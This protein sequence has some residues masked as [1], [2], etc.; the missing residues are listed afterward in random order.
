MTSTQQP[1]RLTQP[2]ISDQQINAAKSKVG[3]T[4]RAMLVSVESFAKRATLLL[5]APKVLRE[6]ARQQTSALASGEVMAQLRKRPIT[7]LRDLMGKGTRF[8][9]LT[10]AGYRTI[11][12]VLATNAHALTRTAGVGEHTAQQVSWAARTLAE[13]AYNDVTVRLDPGRRDPAETRLLATLAALGHADGAVNTLATPLQGFIDH[14]APLIPEAER[15]GSRGRMLFAGRKKKR[16]ALTALAQLDAI[17]ANAET[18]ALQETVDAHEQAID[19][20]SYDPEQLWRDYETEAAAFNALLSTV[21]GARERDDESAHGFIPPELRQKIT[22][23]PLDSSLLVATLRGYQEFGAQYA[24]HQSRAIL[25]DEM[26]LGKTVQALAVMAHLAAHG[27]KRF[28][29][30]CPA[31]V[32]VN[33]M[34]EIR[35]HSKLDAHSLHGDN[36]VSATRIWLRLGGIGVTTFGTLAKL[37]GIDDNEVALLVIDE[38]HFVK[39]PK[40][41]RSLAVAKALDNAQRSLLLTGT[42]MENKVEEFQTL[43]GYLNPSIASTVVPS[44]AIAGARAFR[45][46]VAPVYLRRNQEDV[47]TEL[48]EKIETEDWVQLSSADEIAYRESVQLRNLMRMRQAAFQAPDSAKLERLVQLIDDA[49]EDRLKVVVFSFFL[50][51]LDRVRSRLD[52]QILFGPLT[53][54]VPPA[55]RQEMLNNFARHTGHGVLLGQIDAGGVGVNAQ[56]ASVVILAEPQWKPS[57]E[58]QAIARVHR[59]G[60]VRKVQVHRL[61]AKGSVDER[62]LEVQAHKRLLFDE[63]ARK[64]DAKDANPRA[65]DPG[66]RPGAID[67]EKLTIEQRIIVAEEHRLG[68]RPNQEVNS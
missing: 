63:Y 34:N 6:S 26:G 17:L 4:A 22:A 3:R 33:W 49:R 19:T 42:P 57:T 9:A 54:S 62:L 29:V 5:S 59:M 28:L 25:G 41:K 61:L 11:G 40:A 51:V 21:G 37:P 24:I 60:Q 66:T 8:G 55:A 38:A 2:D 14:T 58:E 30:V 36:R 68:I 35:K 13:H 50:G 52:D 39:N 46:A 7:D 31:S 67:N 47:L 12:D 1:P 64:S 45:R 27:Q 48:P 44:E 10:R 56:T 20:R 53:G 43:V 18:V 15:A 32:L 65:T 23:V 16:G